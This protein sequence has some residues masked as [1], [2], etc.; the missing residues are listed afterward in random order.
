MLEHPS[1]RGQS[2]QT[3]PHRLKIPYSRSSPRTGKWH[4]EVILYAMSKENITTT[5]P[6]A[7]Y[8]GGKLHL[9]RRIC[10]IIDADNHTTYAEA[11]VGMGGIFLRRKARPKAEIINDVNREISTLFRILDRHYPQFI[12]TLKFQIS[13]RADFERLKAVDPD[14]LTD[15]ERAA[16]FLYLQS[17]SFGG[18]PRHNSFGVSPTVPAQFNLMTLIPKLEDL[19][20]RLAGVTIECLNYKDF[21][22]RYDRAGTFFYLDP[23]YFGCENNYGKG[24]FA[25]EDFESMAAILTGLKGRFLMSI[26]DVPQIR[27][28]FTAFH[29]RQVTTTYT[30]SQKSLGKGQ[31]KELLI[32]NFEWDDAISQSRPDAQQELAL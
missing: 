25:R 28:T 9:A 10:A 29:I 16:R 13:T 26:N 24:L 19:H 2:R 11:F 18:V 8:Q 6:V 3:R 5:Q 20:S 1:T 23:P 14:T 31:N 21:I 30:V 22:S 27:E 15:L 4:N 32:S 7:P 17:T 12:D